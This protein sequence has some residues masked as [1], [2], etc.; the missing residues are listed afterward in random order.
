MKQYK[1]YFTSVDENVRLEAQRLAESMG[2]SFS[3]LVRFLLMREI[4]KSKEK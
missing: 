1:I 4:Q 3:Q 2:M